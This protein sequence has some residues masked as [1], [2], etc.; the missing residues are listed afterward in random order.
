MAPCSDSKI[1]LAL[2]DTKYWGTSYNPVWDSQQ[3]TVLS[4]ESV[5]GEIFLPV[6][7]LL[8][9][10]HVKSSIMIHTRSGIFG[11]SPSPLNWFSFH[12][13]PSPP[14]LL[15]LRNV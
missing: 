12:P 13:L 14:F 11:M 1:N 10:E 2:S 3:V 9:F 4:L 5:Y 6:F 7:Q 15:R 8:R